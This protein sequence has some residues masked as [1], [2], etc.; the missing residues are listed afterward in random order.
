MVGQSNTTEVDLDSQIILIPTFVSLQTID[1]SDNTEAVLFGQS[2]CIEEVCWLA[3]LY[4]LPRDDCTPGF[5]KNSHSMD[6]TTK[7]LL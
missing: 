6:Q 2:V 1:R 5:T 7:S 4:T 3:N